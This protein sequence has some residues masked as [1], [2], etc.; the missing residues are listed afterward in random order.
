[1]PPARPH[2]QPQLVQHLVL[3]VVVVQ[4]RK[5]DER[6]VHCLVPRQHVC[7]APSGGGVA[8]KEETGAEQRI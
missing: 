8:Q 5:V 4:V 3:S 2:L 7:G 1:M 6:L